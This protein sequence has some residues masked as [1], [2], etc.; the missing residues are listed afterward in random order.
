MIFNEYQSDLDI[1]GRETCL[2]LDSGL[3][4]HILLLQSRK[5]LMWN[6]IKDTERFAFVNKSLV[7]NVVFYPPSSENMSG[8][9]WIYEDLQ[10]KAGDL[11]SLSDQLLM[12]MRRCVRHQEMV[13]HGVW[14]PG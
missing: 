12:R 1:G 10:T 4:I 6:K 2:T 8:D 13:W 14:P 9:I 3:T 11:A 7:E 5:P